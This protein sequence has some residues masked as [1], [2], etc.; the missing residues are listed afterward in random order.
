MT[1]R[2]DYGICPSDGGC[3]PLC[4]AC[5]ARGRRMRRLINQMAAS[6]AEAKRKMLIDVIL[7][8][9]GGAEPSE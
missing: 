5:R 9:D 4:A 2:K 3:N 8:D 6:S 1:K 7:G